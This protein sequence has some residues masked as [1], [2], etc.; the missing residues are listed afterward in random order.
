[1]DQRFEKL[2]LDYT[3]AGS[4]EERQWIEQ[5]LWRDFGCRKLVFVLDMSGFSLLTRKYG[6]IH[7]LSLIKQMHRIALPIIHKHDGIVVKFE[8]D[9]CF[10]MFDDALPA[11][12][13]SIELN[14]AFNTIN[15]YSEDPFDI[16]ISIGMDYGEV[17]LT[18]GPDYYGDAVNRASKL[19]EDVACPGEIF[20][21]ESAFAQLPSGANLRGKPLELSVAGIHLRAFNLQY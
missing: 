3:L 5:V 10:A 20:L 14:D 11:V 17:L 18:G 2:L 7:Y 16:R 9:N 8:A 21:T 19:G 4:E 12:Q 6:I 15:E 1:M 13:A